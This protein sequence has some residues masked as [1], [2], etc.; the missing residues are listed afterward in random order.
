MAKISIF[1]RDY[2]KVIK[3]N[4]SLQRVDVESDKDLVSID[5][6]KDKVLIIDS[7]QNMYLINTK[8]E[9]IDLT[10][11]EYISQNGES[12]SKGEILNNDSNYLWHTKGKIVNDEKVVYVT[13]IPKFDDEL[14]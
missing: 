10:L 1:S 4:D 11:N 12:I 14:K 13:N 9:I 6:N 5:I 3:N 8:K 7:N 2:D